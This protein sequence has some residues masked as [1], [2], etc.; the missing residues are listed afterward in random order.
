M[1][2][3]Y[4]S[5]RAISGIVL[6]VLIVLMLL[7]VWFVTS[8]PASVASLNSAAYP[9]STDRLFLPYVLQGGS[10]EIN[11]PTPNTTSTRTPTPT[12]TSTRTPTATPTTCP[13]VPYNET[14]RYN[15]D[16]INA[17]EAWPCAAGGEGV[18]I[19]ILD[20]GADSDHPDLVANLVAGA[21][22][23]GTSTEDDNGHG[24]HVSGIAAGVANNGG[25]FGVAPRAKIMPVK[26]L[27]SAGSGTFVAI[28]NGITWAADHGAKVINMSLGSTTDSNIVHSA[29]QY[30]YNKSVVIIVSS[31]NCGSNYYDNGCTYQNQSSY[32]GAYNEVLAV[33]A[34]DSSDIKADFSTAGSYVD[35]SAPGVD[36]YSSNYGNSYA[37]HSGT[38][39][40]A[41]HVAGMAA[42]IRKLR[43]AW[44][45]DQI[46]ACIRASVDDVGSVGWDS[47]TGWGRIN[48][49]KA[50]DAL[51]LAAIDALPV[52]APVQSISV[53]VTS[54]P[55]EFSPG[56]VLFKL[57][58]G[59]ALSA[60]LGEAGINAAGLQASVAVAA[61]DVLQ[62]HVPA[63][64]ELYWLK[65]LRSLPEVDYAELDE[66]MHIQ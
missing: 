11:T 35:V 64:E 31:G 52:P 45:V 62:L 55:A 34:T 41:P 49:Q 46:Y 16:K 26:V 50:V 59:I 3:S 30:A 33:A 17:P 43:P 10:I 9:A 14:L 32:P 22:A 57:R 37:I 61:L 21:Y 2:T 51:I 44:T 58:P 18:I 39:Q 27:N 48:A 20:T 66:I 1:P 23:Y 65:Y 28:A 42:L 60:V 56:I 47:G 19:A 38:S 12:K 36:I 4:V 13:S 24:T 54:D 15:M 8:A 7:L 5:H 29:V 40:A 63:G 6:C 53:S 25:I